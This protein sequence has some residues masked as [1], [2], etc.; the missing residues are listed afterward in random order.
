MSSQRHPAFAHKVK[1][2]K[3][4]VNIGSLGIDYHA[5]EKHFM[6]LMSIYDGQGDVSERIKIDSIVM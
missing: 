2:N 1:G 6:T 5:L 4:F 3:I